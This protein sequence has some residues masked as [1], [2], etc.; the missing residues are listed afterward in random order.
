MNN[1]E[2]IDREI[3]ELK[4]RMLNVKGTD[5]EVYTRIVGYYRSVKNWNKGKRD[6]YNHRKLFS[7]PEKVS[8]KE[9]AGT[10]V[11]TS[12]YN[13]A[14]VPLFAEIQEEENAPA[15]YIYFYRT[16]CPNCPPVKNWLE[17]FYL[18]GKAINVDEK[19]GFTMAAEYK[20]FSSPTVIFLDAD[21]QE[22]TRATN[23]K[24]LEELFA[25]VAV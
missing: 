22:V 2:T 12:T 18:D 19:E 4:E 9:V 10:V 7:Q 11:S 8:M 23:E 5:T 21:G 1:I 25:G 17:N 13:N 24:A 14:Q 3:N 15:S 16:T 6:E 20:I